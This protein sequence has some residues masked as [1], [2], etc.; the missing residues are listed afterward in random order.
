MFAKLSD[1]NL[2]EFV[3]NQLQDDLFARLSDLDL[4]DFPIRESQDTTEIK[5]MQS[6]DAMNSSPQPQLSTIGQC[7]VRQIQGYVSNYVPSSLTL[8]FHNKDIT[9]KIKAKFGLDPHPWQ[10]S[11]VVDIAHYKKDVFVIAGTNA[12]K[13]LT[14]QS[15]LK[16]TGG[17]VLV[18]SPTIAFI[19]DQ[20]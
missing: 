2:Q 1:S 18:I 9:A 19:K 14:Y 11:V 15:R 17:I 7:I 8:G 20:M 16:V 10:V 6:F 13:S 5:D 4:Q 3:S 12:G